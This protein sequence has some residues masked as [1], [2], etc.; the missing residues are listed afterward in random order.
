MDAS[1]MNYDELLEFALSLAVKIQQSGAETYRVEETITRL[2]SAYGIEADASVIPNCITVSCKTPDG[3]NI[4]TLRRVRSCDTQLD[5]IERYSALS[6]KLCTEKPDLDEAW[7]LLKST[8]A[9]VRHYN[10]WI[11]FLGYFLVAFGFAFFFKG[12]FFDAIVA[13]FC[14]LATGFSLKLMG[15]LHANPFFSTLVSGF[16][17]SFV[18]HCCGHLGLCDNVD[19]VSIGALMILVP[20]FLFTNSLRDII[21]GDTMSGVNRLV[22]VLIIAVALVV[23]TSAAVSFATVLF[24]GI[25]S[26]AYLVTYSLPIQCIAGMIGTLGFCLWFNIHGHGLL[27]CLLG[28]IISWLVYSLCAH[29]NMNLYGCYFIAAAVVSLYA[30]IMARIRKYPATSY[31]LASLVPL[32]PGAGVYYT[33]SAIA[34]NDMATFSQKGVETAAIAGSIAIGIL[35]V[36]SSFRMLS[37]YKQRRACKKAAK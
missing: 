29:F 35:L 19:A 26:G 12:T 15:N 6:R 22:Q 18:A 23:G 30:E 1:K 24:G 21:Y 20:G 8:T 28:S 14:G 34:R 5:A 7:A 13:G 33:M 16:I 36:S 11:I 10:A 27:L 25:E 17:L 32:I 9:N 31:L 2:L 37:V 3:K 4:S